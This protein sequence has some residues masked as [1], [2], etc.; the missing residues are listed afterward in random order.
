[1]CGRAASVVRMTRVV[2]RIGAG[3]LLAI[4]TLLAVLALVT[5][6][7]MPVG[8]V[9]AAAVT[10]TPD[11]AVQ[12]LT[13]QLANC[14]D[15]LAV[16]R[17]S[18]E[19]TDMN[20]CITLA[21]R[22]LAALT[23]TPP[24]TTQPPTPTPTGSA[25]PS[26]TPTATATGSPTV[27]PTSTVTPSPSVTPTP[28]P[29]GGTC[30]DVIDS[31]GRSYSGTNST[32]C[33]PVA[34]TTGVP[35]GTTLTVHGA[36]DVMVAGTVIDG[37][38]IYG[39]LNIRA[40]NVTVRNSRVRCAATGECVHSYADG[41]RVD[42]VEIG[43]DTGYAGIAIMD[44]GGS[45]APA[46]RDI[47]SHVNAHNT[48]DGLRCDGG[49]SLTDSWVHNLELGG[50][51]HSDGCQ[52]LDVGGMEFDGNVIEGGNTS[53]FLLQSHGPG[54]IEVKDNLLLGVH[55]SGVQTSY[56]L[57]VDGTDSVPPGSVYFHGNVLNRDWQV[58]PFSTDT[59]AFDAAHW[60]QNR[61]TDGASIG[62]PT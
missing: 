56:A 46:S 51:A 27:S 17:T 24:P 7:A 58:G 26:V 54:I 32:G 16:A 19:R 23:S 20:R 3:P 18:A 14:Q 33:W 28:T 48:G 38:D 50:G 31:L 15:M 61:Y 49:F 8:A 59:Y 43:P 52:A 36:T 25:S 47:Y 6:W 53:C 13:N 22:A 42:H 12:R 9:P 41:L 45:G 4:V 35:A 37:W 34:A 60:Y 57:N 29:T 2:R 40:D 21:Q 55:A 62:V 11:P 10:V 1:V 39:W 5:A 30:A 44:G